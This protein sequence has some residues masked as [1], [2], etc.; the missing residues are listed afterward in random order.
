MSGWGGLTFT[1]G[2]GVSS[3]TG[4]LA[5]VLASRD[6]VEFPFRSHES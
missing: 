5:A 3:S 4:M 2:P 6:M 1:F